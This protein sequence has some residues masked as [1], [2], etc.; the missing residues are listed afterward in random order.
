MY[1]VPTPR[2]VVGRAAVTDSL[3]LLLN[4]LVPVV[5]FSRP[6]LLEHRYACAT[7]MSHKSTSQ[8]L[9]IES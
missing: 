7:R 1:T 6:Q 4:H 3:D 9:S 5:D 8:L 2:P